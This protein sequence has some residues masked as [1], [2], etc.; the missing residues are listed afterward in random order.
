MS[1][2]T[3]RLIVYQVGQPLRNRVLTTSQTFRTTLLPGFTLPLAQLFALAN[4]WGE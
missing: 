4:R 2:F 1:R 3:Q